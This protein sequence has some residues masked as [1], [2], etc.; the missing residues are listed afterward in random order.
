M[1][2]GHGDDYYKSRQ[3]ILSNYSSN[4][5]YGA[6][7]E[8]LK[9]HLFEVFDCLNCYPEPDAGSLRQLLAEVN[10]ILPSEVL[11][12]NGSIT[13][14]YLIAQTWAGKHS[15]IFTPSFAEYEDAC[16]LHGH[17]L[18]FFKNSSPLSAL[19]FKGGGLCWICNPNNPDG[20][21]ISRSDMIG[22]IDSH[23][24]TLFVIDQVYSDFCMEHLFDLE[25]IHRYPNLILVQSISKLHKIP[26]VRIGYVAASED[27]ISKIQ[28]KLIPWSVNAFAIEA[29]KYTLQ[30]PEQFCLPLQQWL[31]ES[32]RLQLQ[33]RQL[34][35]EVY[36][37]SV[38]FF[39]NRL[40]DGFSAEE[41][42]SFLWERGILIRDASNFR[43]LDT[44]YFR[45]STQS[46]E[47]NIELVEAMYAYLGRKGK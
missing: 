28:P 23:P 20:K 1:L 29:G 3:A 13:A 19:S 37:S 41:L 8:P 24:D 33:I 2:F 39:L 15:T 45:L 14:F 31:D 46:R 22:L 40:P 42:K 18:S 47:E 4:V 7:L 36:P 21:L 10:H 9:E 27:L 11:V 30:H 34:G 32:L 6:D 26:G 17:Q 43:G 5:W 25:D 35:I 16:R 12:T 44:S 38:P